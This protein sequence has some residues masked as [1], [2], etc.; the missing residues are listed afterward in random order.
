M[1]RNIFWL[2]VA[3]L[4]VMALTIAGCAQPTEAPTEEAPAEEAPTEAPPPTEE[5]TEAPPE[6]EEEEIVVTLGS[7]EDEIGA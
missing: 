7:W 2:L 5:P 1:K 6:P 4:A 3:C